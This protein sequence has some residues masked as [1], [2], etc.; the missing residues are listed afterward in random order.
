MQKLITIRF[1]S[2]KNKLAFLTNFSPKKLAYGL[3]FIL[4][5]IAV[6]YFAIYT[7]LNFIVS[8]GG[9]GS[10][11][12]K[13][14]IFILFFML[15]FLVSVS[16]GV[17]FYGLSFKSKESQFLLSL[18]MPRGKILSF[19]FI[20]A[21]VFASWIPFL[22]IFFFF[23]AYSNIG[24]AG[25]S[26]ALVSLIFSAPFFI[27][28]CFFGYLLTLF[29]V[30]HFN[31]KR[32][33]YTAGSIL[34]FI[35]I[36]YSNFVISPERED[37]FYYLSEEVAFLK[38]SK[39]WFL[40]FSWP[41]YGIIAFEDY[42]FK[43]SFLYLANLWSLAL[44]CLTFVSSPR[45]MFI[46]IYHRQFTGQGKKTK[47][48]DYLTS[49]FSLFGLPAYLRSFIVKDIKLFAREPSLWLQFLV[50]FGILFFYFLNLRNFSYHLLEPMWRNL[51]TF[52]NT[53]SI[54]C[55]VSAM[56][57]RF[58]FPQWSLEGRNFW[59]L[60]LAPV[61]LKKILLEKFLLTA[62]ALSI[63]SLFLISFSNL[64]L[65]IT[66]SFFFFTLFIILV[67][68]ITLV[69]ISLGLGGYFVNF[70]DEYYLKAVESLGGFITIVIS[71]GYAFLTISVF[72]FLTHLY[73]IGKLPRFKMVL[74]VVVI[75]WTVLSILVSLI[76]LGSGMR[77]LSQKEY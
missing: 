32:I 46:S 69:S 74:V 62:T 64:M 45:K 73:F 42:D 33:F 72:S 12:I 20:E 3:I 34:I 6:I 54:L 10:I 27:I 55:I 17:L 44:L 35:S 57:I 53:F 48:R 14:I 38:F 21:A 40:P 36:F 76:S 63:I 75:L 7:G 58:V 49:V 22:G 43:K 60:K 5:S 28:S 39:M 77:E 67:S 11:I 37:I 23:L 56:S 66:P 9:L 15:F 52:L 2:I 16:F 24:N 47:T 41:G 8:L 1:F 19:K 18:P 26:L 51:L 29:V 65:R 25:T 71:F 31:L 30:R 13:K 50:F 59:I 4:A 68:T 70:K 61:S